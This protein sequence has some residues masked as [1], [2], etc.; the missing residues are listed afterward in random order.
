MNYRILSKNLG[1]IIGIIFILFALSSCMSSEQGFD[2]NPKISY[3]AP[4]YLAYD[5]YQNKIIRGKIKYHKTIAQNF[6]NGVLNETGISEFFYDKRGNEIK[7]VRFDTDG[8][9]YRVQ[10]KHHDSLGQVILE[11]IEDVTS[12]T[13]YTCTT[14]YYPDSSVETCIPN[15]SATHYRPGEVPH[16]NKM[17]YYKNGRDSL[18]EYDIGGYGYHKIASYRHNEYD[19]LIE[20]ISYWSNGDVASITKTLF[21]EKDSCLVY[22]HLTEKRV[23]A[24]VCPGQ[25]KRTYHFYADEEINF[26]QLSVQMQKGGRLEV[27]FNE[28]GLT[29]LWEYFDAKG[30]L[31]G[32]I[33]SIYEY[34]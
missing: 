7:E 32:R 6:E 16:Y 23:I 19:Q 9:I 1:V 11:Y 10:H 2:D 15:K 3:Y 26:Y 22:Y 31:V 20:H 8:K 21:Y 14:I 34:Y 18:L 4:I 29:S 13:I 25:T 27:T 30:A 5:T 12:D 33:T 28:F 17:T 24:E